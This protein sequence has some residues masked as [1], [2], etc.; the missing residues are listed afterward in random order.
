M[1]AF[2]ICS[3]STSAVSEARRRSRGEGQPPLR[4]R[5][6]EADRAFFE[7]VEQGFQ[8]IARAEPDRFK[9][10]EATGSIEQV[11]AAVWA[12]VRRRLH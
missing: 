11:A 10:I 9:V 8:V 1:N 12:E 5:I 4:D 7:R 3:S 6:E 2:L